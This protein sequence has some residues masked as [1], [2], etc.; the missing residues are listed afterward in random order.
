MEKNTQVGYGYEVSLT[1]NSKVKS[2]VK[3]DDGQYFI[4]S[5]RI[6]RLRHIMRRSEGMPKLSLYWF[7]N[8]K[9]KDKGIDLRRD[10]L[11]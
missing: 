9:E 10:E 7:E 2:K 11:M 8:R 3:N 5:Q 1:E 4:K 6:Q